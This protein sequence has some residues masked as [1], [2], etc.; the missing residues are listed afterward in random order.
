MD[1]ESLRY[2]AQQESIEGLYELIRGD[3]A[4]QGSVDALYALIQRDA[5]VLDRIDEIPF[6]DTPLHVA[7]YAGHTR[8]AMEIMRLKPSFARKLNKDG[9]SPMHLALQ[10]N[11]TQVVRQLLDVDEDLVRVQG[12]EGV[13]PLHYATQ[14]GDLHLLVEFLKACPKSIE[15][16][17]IQRETVLH[18]ALKHNM[19]DAFRLLLGWLRRAWFKNASLWEKKLLNWQDEEGNTV[20]HIAVSKNQPQIVR[21]ILN[22]RSF[23]RCKV[24]ISAKNFRGYRALDMLQG[25]KANKQ[26]QEIKDMLRSAKCFSIFHLPKVE[27]FAD[28]LKS[29]VQIDEKIYIFFLRQRTKMTNDTRNIL[30]VVAALLVTVTFQATLSP[31]GGVWQDN[32]L[33]NSVA[34]TGVI[35]EDAH[36]AGTAV[37]DEYLF[38]V[39]AVLNVISF[40]IT[41]FTIFVLLPSGFRSGM[42]FVPLYIFSLCFVASLLITSPVDFVYGL[43]GQQVVGFMF[44][45]LLVPVLEGIVR[46]RQRKLFEAFLPKVKVLDPTLT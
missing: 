13:T 29:P 41:V 30:L 2:A 46:C 45:P 1:I 14:T 28:Y 33:A 40:S 18:I 10:N 17:T 36:Y 39:L 38:G 9:F 27:S 19:F 23:F 26:N 12:R 8:F 21:L 34:P 20:L 6:V 22:F 32:K 44:S 31:P 4:Q 16:I 7:A 15:D 11:R 43:N 24:D 5:K 37:M 35:V 3:A 25:N 42:F